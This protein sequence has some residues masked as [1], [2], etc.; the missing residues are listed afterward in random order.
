MLDLKTR[1]CFQ[2]SKYWV[3]GL[4]LF[5]IVCTSTTN[6]I[7]GSFVPP[8]QRPQPLKPMKRRV[9]WLPPFVTVPPI[10]QVKT[11]RS[12]LALLKKEY[13]D[14]SKV[15]NRS[16]RRQ[17]KAFGKKKKTVSATAA[18]AGA[19]SEQPPA[20]PATQAEAEAP[21]APKKGMFDEVKET[22]DAVNKQSYYQALALNKELEDKG[23]LPPLERKP[24]APGGDKEEAVVDEGGPELAT[25]AATAVA[26]GVP[27][28]E[29][30]VGAAASTGGGSKRRK[31][32]KGGKKGKR[33]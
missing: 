11:K 30:A 19:T 8:R 25:K 21:A 29:E 10:A 14:Q 4:A 13:E 28:G 9:P 7:R 1:L 23:M 27:D 15:A 6:V 33:K 16:T 18:A 32:G 17:K 20:P 26:A 5:S 24:A 3:S 2:L 12:S 22:L 31:K